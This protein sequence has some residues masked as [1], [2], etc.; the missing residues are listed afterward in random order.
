MVLPCL[1]AGPLDK[2]DN[3]DQA[4]LNIVGVG[5]LDVAMD[6]LVYATGDPP[7]STNA[8]S[9]DTGSGSLT[10]KGNN[11]GGGASLSNPIL[12]D[13]VQQAAVT[14]EDMLDEGEDPDPDSDLLLNIEHG[15]DWGAEM[16]D[17]DD[18]EI[19]FEQELNC[20]LLVDDLID[21]IFERELADTSY[22]L[23]ESDITLL[24]HFAL[25]IG[26]HMTNKAFAKLTYAFP[27][28]NVDSWKMTKA[29]A[30][31]L[32]QFTP[33][34][35]DCCVNSCVCYVGP[36]KKETQCPH[37]EEPQFCP[38]TKCPRK[39][40]KYLPIVPQLC[41]FYKS[42]SMIDKV[43]YCALYQPSVDGSINDVMDSKHCQRLCKHVIPGPKK[44]KD[45][46]SFI[47][48][49]VR[50][51]LKLA[52]G[53]HVFDIERHEF[54]TL[55]AYLVLIFGDIPAVSMV[56]NIKGHNGVCPCCMCNIH[57]VRAPDSRVYYVPLD[58]QNF[59]DSPF[60]YDPQN[61]PLCTDDEMKKQAEEVQFAS[62]TAQSNSLAIEYGIKGTSVLSVLPSLS[63]PTSFPYDF[64][65]LIFENI[66][67]TLVLLW[68]GDFK[69]LDEGTGSYH[70]MPKVW[71]AIGT[72]MA[73]YGTDD[74]QATTADSWSFWLLHL[75]SIL[76]ESKF[77]SNIYYQHFL[78][79]SV[80]I[81]KCMQFEI[82]YT[83]VKSIQEMCSKWVTDFERLYFQYD[84][85]CVSTCPL[86][87]HGLL[88]VPDAIEIGPV[89]MHW[90]FPIECFC[91][92]LQPAIKSRQYPFAAIDN[93]LIAQAQLSQIK[94]IYNVHKELSLKPP[95][96][97]APRGSFISPDYP[98]CILLPPQCPSSSISQSLKDKIIIC[99]AT[100]FNAN[101]ATVQCHIWEDDMVKW[102]KVCCLDG[103]DDMNAST[104]VPFSEDR[105]DVTFVR[106]SDISL[107]IFWGANSLPQYDMLVD[108]NARR[109]TAAPCFEKQ[110]FFG[111]LENIIVV[112]VPATTALGLES[113]T[114]F[115]LAAIQKCKVVGSN[116]RGVHYYE[117]MGGLEV[118]DITVV[119]CLV[120][121]VKA[122][123]D[124]R[125]FIIDRSD[126]LQASFYVPGE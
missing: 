120:G 45:F 9:M 84:P 16:D 30:A 42:M 4:D 111:Q 22:V 53:V 91:G 123:N 23:S 71:E 99:L 77:Q 85:E 82:P 38:N 110:I 74:K 58:H 119:Q 15:I 98:T 19:D 18:N 93:Y 25:K 54:F 81:E 94:L 57:G 118:V 10:S 69:G 125:I 8:Q 31:S 46:N 1:T 104:L 13:S 34:R 72:A 20:S 21:E 12:S 43:K 117:Q 79:L 112:T 113:D 86:T 6:E 107:A 115:I 76:L 59:P 73:A 32:C 106:M 49:L 64:M 52:H 5:N 33:E 63:F 44:L 55:H 67:K 108:L 26:T 50:E 37:C 48:P 29:H 3:A 36:H 41:A 116:A 7:A 105:R 39:Q 24:C 17:N 87:V 114:L 88:H 70:F 60:S 61:L 68:T 121:R 35:Y 62:S 90:A 109:Q 65:H 51:L 83:E 126:T 27:D 100:Q 95:S 11:I 80:I 14:N 97:E 75:S 92:W 102:G 66:L 103:G 124:G 101:L 96:K 56:M 40:F 122:V 2:V 28:G 89:W 47:W 78:D